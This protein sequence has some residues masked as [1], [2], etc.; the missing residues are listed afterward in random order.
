[1]KDKDKVGD[2]IKTASRTNSFKNPTLRK[3][4]S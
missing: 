1:M 3:R 2:S 4:R